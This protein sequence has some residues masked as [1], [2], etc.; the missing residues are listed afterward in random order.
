[1]AAVKKPRKRANPNLGQPLVGKK[2]RVRFGL[3]IDPDLKAAM[4]E[5]WPEMVRSRRIGEAIAAALG[6]KLLHD[7]LAERI[8]ELSTP[9]RQVV[10]KLLDSIGTRTPR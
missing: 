2:L 4:E 8:R 1:M 7:E 6:H 5:E 9:Q 10:V 3:W